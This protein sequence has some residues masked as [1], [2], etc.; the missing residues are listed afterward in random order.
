L[1][2]NNKSKKPREP[3]VEEFLKFRP[4][5]LDF[6]WKE[7]ADGL[8]EIK[9]PKFNSNFGKSFCKFIKKDNHFSANLDKLGSFIWKEIDGTKT[10]Q[11]VLELVKKD[12]PGQEEDIDQRLFLF[13]RQMQS[14]N[15]IE[16]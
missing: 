7:K 15:Y 12:F 6:S 9:V 16:L 5:R 3:T 14:L 4:R 2:K 11:E 10:V 8:V 1:L 13:L